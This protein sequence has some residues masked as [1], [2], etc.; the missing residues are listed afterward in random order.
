MV[1]YEWS[2]L[3]EQLISAFG[4][5]LFAMRGQNDARTIANDAWYGVD[6][7]NNR[8]KLLATIAKRRFTEDQL[9][10][11]HEIISPEIRA[12]ATERNRIV[13][14][15][16]MLCDKYP[17]DLVL[18]TPK[19]DHR[20]RYS[21]QD[22]EQV[23][24]RIIDTSN[25]TISFWFALEQQTRPEIFQQLAQMLPQLQSPDES[26]TLQDKTHP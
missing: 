17:T 13:H 4:F 15:N 18:E 23:V 9:R 5:C 26:P 25:K 14:G 1:A 12:R 20:R 7:L 2:S 21:V 16:W 10:P 24:D 8:L 6:G 22:F 19:Q 11:F 3:E